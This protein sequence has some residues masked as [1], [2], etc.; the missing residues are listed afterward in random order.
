MSSSGLVSIYRE[1]M[2]FKGEFIEVDNNYIH[3]LHCHILNC[4]INR[5][6][7]FVSSM[8]LHGDH[9]IWTSVD[10]Q[11]SGVHYGIDM[12]QQGSFY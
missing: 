3:L 5:I 9:L 7:N 12:R 1:V 8:Y 10:N 6:E 4:E 2:S 11:N